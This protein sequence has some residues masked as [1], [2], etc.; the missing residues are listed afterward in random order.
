MRPDRVVAAAAVA[1]GLLAR[2][3]LFLSP[4]ELETQ[5]I[6]LVLVAGDQPAVGFPRNAH[7]RRAVDVNYRKHATWVFVQANRFRK[8]GR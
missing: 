7:R 1:N 8:L 3:P 6:V 2:R 4:L 5:V